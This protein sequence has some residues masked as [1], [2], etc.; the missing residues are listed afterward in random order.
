MVSVA[1]VT[2]VVLKGAIILVS[3]LLAAGIAGFVTWL[4]LQQKKYKQYKCVIWGMDGF[5]QVF[6]EYDNAGIYVDPKTNNKRLFL[7]KNRV[8]LNADKIPFIQSGKSKIVYLHKFGLKNFRFLKPR[9]NDD[10]M[11]I[12]VGEEDVNW[13]LNSYERGKKIF[14]QDRLLQFMPYIAIAFVSIVILIIFIYL[15]RKLDTLKE[16]AQALTEMVKH[17]KQMTAGT[18]VLE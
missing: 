15:F 16:V 5:G 1:G 18:V 12:D 4:I 11:E 2:D 17:A 13:A 6:E 7:K 10:K 14:S 8:G 3:L 9:L